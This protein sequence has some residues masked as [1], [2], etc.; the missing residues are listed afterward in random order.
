MRIKEANVTERLREEMAQRAGLFR[1]LIDHYGDGVL[2]VVAARTDRLAEVSLREADLVRR[3]LP[4]VM[5]QLWDGVDDLIDF[6]IIEQTEDR[7]GIRVVRC[8]FADEMRKHEAGD[9]GFAFYCAYDD[10]F[11]RGL[12]PAIRFTRTKT[13]MK[14]DDC[15]DH[16]YE[17]QKEVAQDG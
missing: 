15:C 14:G 8:L 10:G 16:A 1:E 12:N 9:I 17:L 6:D 11:C 5:E 7:L 2:D 4:A 13:L 3:D